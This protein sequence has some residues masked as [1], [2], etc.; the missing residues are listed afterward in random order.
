MANANGISL[1]QFGLWYKTPGTPIVTYYS[2]YDVKTGTLK[3][4]LEQSSKNDKPLHIPV[5]TGLIDKSTG[6][7]V[8]PTKVLE[9][10]IGLTLKVG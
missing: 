10:I 2:E 7:E 5:S 8:V 6:E 4:M 9:Y 3:L 1:E